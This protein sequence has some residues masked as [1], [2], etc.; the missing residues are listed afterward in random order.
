ML[1]SIKPKVAFF[2]FT[3]CEGCQLTVV[4]ALQ[5]HPEL[6]DVVD[7]V[8]FCETMSEKANAYD[9]AVIEGSRSRAR[10]E[11]RLQD[12]RERAEIIVALGACAHLGGVNAIRNQ[13]N[14]EEVRHYVYSA[15]ADWFDVY[16]ARAI[17]EIIDVDAVV[18][19]CPIGRAEFL[20]VVI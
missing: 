4:D 14:L 17:S 15:Y 9:I 19:G 5:T 13:Q 20:T 10:D 3:S 1:K 8:E 16:E 7:I 2:D 6:L 12:I 18:P 11:G